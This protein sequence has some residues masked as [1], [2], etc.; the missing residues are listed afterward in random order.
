[1]SVSL[2]IKQMEDLLALQQSLQQIGEQKRQAVLG[3]RIDELSMWVNRE[4]RLIKQLAE[5]QAAWRKA[6]AHVL[7]QRG[8]HP[9]S[10]MTMTDIAGMIRPEEGRDD[11]LRLQEQLLGVIRR[12]KEDN[13]RNRQ[14]I[15]QSLE[16]VQY[17]LELAAGYR[18]Q[19]V[20]YERPTQ[21]NKPQDGTGRNRFDAR[22]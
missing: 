11:V 13:E 20:I 10:S 14:L 19:D 9:D 8:I 1:M 16:F 12:V 21:A 18:E 7:A 6:V 3:N 5:K 17:T 2:M 15:E 4:S 22:A